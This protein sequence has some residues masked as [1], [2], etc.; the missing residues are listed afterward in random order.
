MACRR[1][2]SS[3]LAPASCSFSTPITCSSLNR[4]CFM[5]LPPR[6]SKGG[7]FQLAMARIPGERSRVAMGWACTA[8]ANVYWD[9]MAKRVTNVASAHSDRRAGLAVGSGAE[10]VVGRVR[11]Y[12]AY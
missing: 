2:I 10:E 8:G 3:T 7:R 6:R 4:L 11:L 9:N 12:G 5:G 1:Q